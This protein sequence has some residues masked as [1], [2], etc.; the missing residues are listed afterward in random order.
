MFSLSQGSGLALLNTNL[1]SAEKF[2]CQAL[3]G[4]NRPAISWSVPISFPFV[5]MKRTHK[6]QATTAPVETPKELK[7]LEN[8]KQG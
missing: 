2:R 5:V 4:E 7:V 6:D 3:K 1:I 8:F